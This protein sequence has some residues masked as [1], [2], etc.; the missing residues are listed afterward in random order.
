[1]PT[2]EGESWWCP[3]GVGNRRDQLSYRMGSPEGE[4][5]RFEDEGPAHDVVIARPF[6]IAATPV[7]NGQY[8]EFMLAHE[9]E[10]VDEHKPVVNVTWYDAV[11]YS[12]W[13]GARLPSEA[14][15]ECA[16]RGGTSSRF[17]SGDSEEELAR[18]GWFRDNAEDPQPVAQNEA[19]AFGLFDVHGTV[20]EWCEDPWHG[21]YDGAPTDGSVWELSEESQGSPLRVVRGGSFLDLAQ[22]CRSAY[23]FWWLPVD[24][25]P[26]QGFRPARFVTE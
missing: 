4:E 16:A 11:M 24:R 21:D 1:V 5:G 26:A 19:N 17:W 15:W 8:R 10:E 7:T 6:E 14:E 3:I 12:R 13:L 20:R 23:R 9:F 25:L 18:V 22:R 2:R